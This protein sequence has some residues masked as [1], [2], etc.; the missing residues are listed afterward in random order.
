MEMETGQMPATFGLRNPLPI[1]KDNAR[2][3]S[4][5]TTSVPIRQTTRDGRRFAAVSS[6]GK[7][8]A[9]HVLLERGE[10]VPVPAAASRPAFAAK[11]QVAQLRPPCACAGVG[12][13]L[14]R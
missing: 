2:L 9:Y 4:A 1:F 6:F 12:C 3:I 8:L 11:P 10:K 13:R 5:A 14:A 7:G